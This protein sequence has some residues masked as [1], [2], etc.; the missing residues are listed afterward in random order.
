MKTI[1]FSIILGLLTP[2]LQVSNFFTFE[3]VHRS[4]V[5]A[6]FS[7][8]QTTYDFKKVKQNVPVSHQF[9]FTNNGGEP[10]VISGVQASCGCTVTEYTK[11]PV[12][13]GSEGYVK[14]TYNAAH[15]GAFS[16]TVTINANTENAVVV[17]TIKGE[18]IN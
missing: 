8:N 2:G 12:Q 17:L 1:A 10:L 14:A 15:T 3:G 6:S 9:K 18:V 13:P 11:E 7:W 4:D 5:A 16:K